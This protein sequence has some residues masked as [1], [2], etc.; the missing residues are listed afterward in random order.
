MTLPAQWKKG[1]RPDPSVV[2]L[3]DAL[4]EAARKGLIR[5]VAVVTVNPLLEVE[6]THAGDMDNVKSNLL[7]GGLVS[8]AHKITRA[9]K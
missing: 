9:D 7:C 1:P 2:E 5:A 3:L 4:Q 6:T 8:A